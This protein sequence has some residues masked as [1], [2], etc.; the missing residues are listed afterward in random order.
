MVGGS[1]G[2]PLLLDGN[3]LADYIE[4]EKVYKRAKLIILD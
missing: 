4:L 3:A 1:V 2:V